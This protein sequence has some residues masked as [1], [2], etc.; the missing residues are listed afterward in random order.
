MMKNPMSGDAWLE[1]DCGREHWGLFGAAGILLHR[2]NA[3]GEKQVLLQHRAAWSDGGSTW[4]I[5]G[6]AMDYNETPHDAAL[7]EAYEEAGVPAGHVLV[8]TE[9]VMDHGNWTYTTIIGEVLT[10][11]DIVFDDESETVE[12]VNLSEVENLNLHPAFANSW[13]ASL[14]SLLS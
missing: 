9:H 2:I 6:G 13:N 14:R 4:G 7:R 5:P 11:F 3:L 10:S 8:Y 1:C 12:W